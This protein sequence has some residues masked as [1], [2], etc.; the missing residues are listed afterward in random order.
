MGLYLSASALWT[1]LSS[2]VR[3]PFSFDPPNLP[4][5][6]IPDR[7]RGPVKARDPSE[8]TVVL[9]LIKTMGEEDG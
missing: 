1:S 5:D 4:V 3:S 2:S 7:S 8:T 6:L 9:V